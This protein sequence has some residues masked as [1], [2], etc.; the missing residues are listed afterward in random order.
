MTY[1]IITNLGY[2]NKIEFLSKLK[3]TERLFSNVKSKELPILYHEN[4][5]TELVCRVV[6]LMEIDNSINFNFGSENYSVSNGKKN[7]R[8]N[9]RT[10]NKIK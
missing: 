6:D 7:D 2:L 4:K 9:Q 1:K 10:D 8:E 3:F 5:L